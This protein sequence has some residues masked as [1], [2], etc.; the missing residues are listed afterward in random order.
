MQPALRLDRVRAQAVDPQTVV[1]HLTAPGDLSLRLLDALSLPIVPQHVHD[2]PG[3]ALD[4]REATPVGSGPFRMAEWLR[5]V[6]FEWYAGPKAALAGIDCPV[7]PDPA[8]RLAL[9]GGGAPVLLAGNAAALSEVP[10]L[11]TVPSLSVEADYPPAARSIAG[12]RL[13][14]AAKPL[15]QQD[16]RLALACAIS[17]ETVLRDAWAGIGRIASGP[18]IGGC[19]GRNDAAVLP[20]F[21]ARVASAHLNAAG[22]RPGD[23]GI[24][25]QLAF[26]HPPDPALRALLAVVRASLRQVGIEVTAE[27]VSAEQWTR[28]CA[29]GD[30]QMAAFLE[31]QSGDPAVDLARYAAGLPGLAPLLGGGPDGLAEAQ[32]VLAASLPVLWLVEPG[33]PV[34][35]DRRLSLPGGVLGDFSGARLD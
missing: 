6:R 33:C 34:A 14:L 16:V 8:A 30:F 24:R 26:L 17:R 20:E 25:T 11:R 9:A 1:L 15:D 21:S 10:R 12:V 2:R 19:A 35:R 28:R 29:S 7:V 4:P 31:S 3:W 27:P 5:L 23:D 18:L 13:N 22:L 32:T